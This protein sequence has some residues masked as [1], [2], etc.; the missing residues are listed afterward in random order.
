MSLDELHGTLTAYEMRM[1]KVKPTE[2]EAAFKAMKKIK[3]KQ[4]SKSDDSDD[5]LIVYLA[6]KLKKGRGKY[7]G[8]LP[9]KC[10]NCGGIGHFGSKCPEKGKTD[11]SD[12]DIHESKTKKGSSSGSE[13]TKGKGTT[14]NSVRFVS[15]KPKNSNVEKFSKKKVDKDGF[16]TVNHQKPKNFGR[17]SRQGQSYFNGYCYWCNVYRHR[18]AECKRQVKPT[19]FISMNRYAPLRVESVECYRLGHMARNCRTIL[20]SQR[21][22]RRNLKK[23]PPKKEGQKQKVDVEEKRRKHITMVEKV[24]WIEKKKK[25]NSDSSLIVQTAFQAHSKPSPWIL[26]SRC[27][28]HMI[29][30]KDKFLNL[31]HVGK[32]SVRFGNNDGARVEGKGKIRLYNGHIS[33]NNAL[34][35]SELKHN[36]LSIS[37]ICDSGNEVLFTK[38]GCVIK[39]TKNGKIVAQGSR[40]AHNLYALSEGLKEMC[41]I[42]KKG[43]LLDDNLE[44]LKDKPEVITPQEQ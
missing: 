40:I 14:G 3:I 15:E 8:K 29:G 27:S 12:E 42:S 6:R 38:D 17:Y 11:D 34:Y 23:N 28:T 21:Q 1:V 22:S 35:V 5:E 2:K 20:S 7:K 32:G 33:S 31:E 43:V 24:V 16:T 4:E 37:Q 30:D 10:F 36:I 44:A 9:L 39:K 26:D 19:N 18:L 25:G 13:K 41:M